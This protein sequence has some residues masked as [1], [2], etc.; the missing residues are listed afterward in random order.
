[1]RP[2]PA[3]VSRYGLTQACYGSFSKKRLAVLSWGRAMADYHA[4]IVRDDCDLQLQL[5]R[6]LKRQWRA[7]RRAMQWGVTY[8]DA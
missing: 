7:L 5:R 8:D 1:L 4:A 3:A 6:H 2:A